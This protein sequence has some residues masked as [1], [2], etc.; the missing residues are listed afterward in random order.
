MS[1]F[2]VGTTPIRIL[3]NNPERKLAWLHVV[4]GNLWIERDEYLITNYPSR[5]FLLPTGVVL[6][7][8][9]WK[10]NVY[11]VSDVTTAELYVMSFEQLQARDIGKQAK[12][13]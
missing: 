11:A 2:T 12:K 4:S 1:V 10:D 13:R 5:G 9:E 3:E 6:D 8:S 7:F